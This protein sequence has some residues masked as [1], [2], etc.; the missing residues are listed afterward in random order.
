MRGSSDFSNRCRSS[1]VPYNA[2][3]RKELYFELEADEA[4]A[5]NGGEEELNFL[6]NAGEL[7]IFRH[8]IIIYLN[9]DTED[10]QVDSDYKDFA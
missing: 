5:L 3:P 8:S 6:Q 1:L 2:R 10:E 7:V 4:V 9:N